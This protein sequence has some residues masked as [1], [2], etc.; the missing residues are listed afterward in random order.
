MPLGSMQRVGLLLL[1][2][3]CLV[4]GSQDFRTGTSGGHARG[5]SQ[6]SSSDSGTQSYIV[7]LK[8]GAD[9]QDVDA[10][11]GDLQNS[12]TTCTFKYG[13]VLVG[14]AAQ[15]TPALASSLQ[16]ASQVD[17]LVLD[18]QVVHQ[19]ALAPSSESS[20]AA[21]AAALAE[22]AA[23]P[24]GAA[25]AGSGTPVVTSAP[26]TAAPNNAPAVLRYETAPNVTWN[27]DRID[28]PSLP[29]D[30]K[31]T[32][33]NDGTGVNIYILDTGVRKTHKEFQYLP[34]MG[35]SGTRALH[36]YSTV[37]DP[38]N[39][40]DCLGHGT[41]VAGLAGGVTYGVAKNVTIYAVK[42]INCDG[43]ADAS[44]VLAGLD[45]LSANVKFPAIASM[46][47]GADTPNQALDDAVT[48]LIQ[49][50]TLAVIAA[51]NYNQDACQL[52]PARV[53]TALTV[54]ASDVTDT[55][56][57]SSN[58][59]SCVDLYSP[60][61]NIL[62]AMDTSNTA[63]ITATG[64]SMATP[65]VSGVAA[66]YLQDNPTASAAEVS[67]NILGTTV[68]G[69]IQN[70]LESTGTPNKLL[71]TYIKVAPTITITPAVLDPVVLFQGQT[72]TGA[73]SQTVTLANAGAQDVYFNVSVL[74][75]GVF[76]GWIA[77]QPTSGSIPAGGSTSFTL[78]YD[79]SQNQFQTTLTAQVLITT[80]GRPSAKA[81][82]AEAYVFCA[83][84]QNALPDATHTT[85]ITIPLVQDTRPISADWPPLASDN[86]TY[87]YFDAIVDFS[88]PVGELN[89][90]S[91]QINDGAGIIEGINSSDAS[92]N[93]LC[94]AFTIRG[95]VPFDPW[96]TLQ[97]TV[98]I[99][100]TGSSVTDVY[101]KT[102]PDWKNTTSLDHRPRGIMFSAYMAFSS[103]QGLITSQQ[104]VV[105]IL[106][107]TEPVTGLATTSFSVSGPTGPTIGG[108]QLVRGTNTYYHVTINVPGDYY[109]GVT[110]TLA[111]S[112]QDASGNTN[113]AVNP[114][115][116]VRV[117]SP[118]MEGTSYRVIKSAGLLSLT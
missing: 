91:V 110:V 89:E 105:L 42:V 35:I 84:L 104:S 92:G 37:G 52:S 78:S 74:P 6:S 27:L 47:L 63:T 69:T 44:N 22:S 118:L 75:N 17:Y 82:M 30:G 65:I 87:V 117:P 66:L 18:N 88:H 54:A 76:G 100:V 79:I 90:T 58:Y 81:M 20:P 34:Y 109:G 8:Q 26:A 112:V 70:A 2:G 10:L 29:L 115:S 114:L 1:A 103:D 111:G 40:D 55:R 48:A 15:L 46:S 23:S 53:S 113:I 73:T 13:Q 49:Q 106:V 39:S 41:H 116:F 11:C 21:Q 59:G 19:Q 101:G 45:W 71:Q 32:W 31:Y 4:Q 5:L 50:G 36:G 97:T 64:T 12:G 72:F 7:R 108:L 57:A 14:F 51:G 61:V 80:S 28:Q 99:T 98:G 24:A 16:N 85:T 3:A 56:W 68:A 60:G 107:F 93:A 67:A 25:A 83:A 96:A 62:S 33:S 102:F 43:T 95:K 77:A 86:G 9:A 38:S 94:G